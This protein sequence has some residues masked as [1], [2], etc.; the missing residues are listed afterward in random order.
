MADTS[1]FPSMM[2][3]NWLKLRVQNEKYDENSGLQKSECGFSSFSE[4]DRIHYYAYHYAWRRHY[5]Q[6]E[7]P[8]SPFDVKGRYYD[9]LL[10]EQAYRA[11]YPPCLARQRITA[12]DQYA[13]KG[14]Y[15]MAAHCRRQDRE[16][17]AARAEIAGT[18]RNADGS[19]V[20]SA[21][22]F[23]ELCMRQI[24]TNLGAWL[25]RNEAAMGTRGDYDAL[26]TDLGVSA[27]EK[28]E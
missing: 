3:F 7:G 17:G 22:A 25:K 16:R 8:G 5:L 13:A 9:P 14:D 19:P 18:G 21:L 1:N 12:A 4:R 20:A 6:Q 2:H 11:L 23:V 10:V 27:K 28:A 26:L 15:R 24:R